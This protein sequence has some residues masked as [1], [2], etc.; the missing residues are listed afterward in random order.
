MRVRLQYSAQRFY[1]SY[2]SEKVKSYRR[3]RLPVLQYRP[4]SASRRSLRA[5]SKPA[6]TI[7]R[8]QYAGVECLV[9]P[10]VAL[11]GDSVVR[12][13]GSLG[14]ELV[15]AAL[16]ASIPPE[17][18]NGRPLV[19]DHPGLSSANDPATLAA[20]SFGQ[21]FNAQFRNNALQM[22][23]WIDPTRAAK[24][25]PDAQDIVDRCLSGTVVE[26][27]VGAFVAVVERAGVTEAGVPY[28]YV[29]VDLHSDHL[30]ALP[31]DIKGACSVEM[32]CGAPRAARAATLMRAAGH[33]KG[34][35]DM[36]SGILSWIASLFRSASSDDMT[37]GEL[38]RALSAALFN[39]EPG[40]IDVIDFN[41][42]QS[43]VVYLCSVA[44]EGNSGIWR[45]VVYERGYTLSES[46]EVALSDDRVEGTVKPTFVPLS[47][48][49][50]GS[51]EGENPESAAAVDNPATSRSGIA[52]PATPSVLSSCQCQTGA[53]AHAH[54]PSSASPLPGGNT[55]MALTAEQRQA[56]ITALSTKLKLSPAGVKALE[57]LTDE[58]LEGAGRELE[59]ANPATPATPPAGTPASTPEAPAA[60]STPSAPTTPATPAAPSAP[61]TA[62]LSAA[63]GTAPA[64]S[65][66][67]LALFRGMMDELRARDAAERTHLI[68]SLSAAPSVS[69]VFSTDQLAAKPTSELR[70]LAA[71][72][73]P[74]TQAY[75]PSLLP[76]VNFS[77]RGM[78]RALAGEDTVP[79]PTSMADALKAN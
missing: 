79:A 22:E 59:T 70:Q 64:P 24:V 38:R 28:E 69:G 77:G 18:W 27:S 12:P 15:P 46:G 20:M 36:K 1:N 78:P 48:E 35:R 14:P 30:A 17:I 61:Q 2:P 37:S 4:V 49:M 62:N 56:R 66:E 47:A 67:D 9:V 45:E 33:A 11:L 5:A 42:F 63:T 55:N 72:A 16:L 41:P 71:I 50:V 8:A 73:L 75:S 68:T 57:G 6:A 25:G 7:R 51:E 60:P 13:M 31:R 21:V 32:G 3:A 39:A 65:A 40:F 19:C 52:S 74:Q 58:V 44:S 23:M 10:V 29:W 26:V 53:G 34:E 43:R 54:T 76:P